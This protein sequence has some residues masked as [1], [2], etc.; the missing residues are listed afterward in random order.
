[1][2][3]YRDLK[4]WIRCNRNNKRMKHKNKFTVTG[5]VTKLVISSNKIQNSMIWSSTKKDELIFYIVFWIRFCHASQK[6]IV[7]AHI[8]KPTLLFS[9]I[10][11]VC[12]YPY[13]GN[14][15]RAIKNKYYKNITTIN[16]D[17]LFSNDIFFVLYKLYYICKIYI[18]VI[19]VNAINWIGGIIFN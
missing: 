3:C 5:V 19:R 15:I 8:G 4:S 17:V 14:F 6:N 1:M 16:F 18:L 9:V 13:I 10:S 12:M 7:Y 2:L 11:I